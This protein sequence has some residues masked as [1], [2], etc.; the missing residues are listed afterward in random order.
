[1]LALTPPPDVS[2]MEWTSIVFWTH[3]LHCNTI[4]QV[5]ASLPMLQTID[6]LIEDTAEHPDKQNIDRLWEEYSK[7]SQSG[8][9]Y[10]E[11]YLPIRDEIAEAISNQ[12]RNYPD[13]R[14]YDDFLASIRARKSTKQ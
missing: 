3:N 5:H 12:G 9:T 1:M 6:K 14:S 8:F 13:V 7:L 10:R 11:K 2:E 4:P